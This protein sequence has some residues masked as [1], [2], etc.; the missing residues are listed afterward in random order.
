MSGAMKQDDL[1]EGTRGPDD[2]FFCQK[3][4]VWYRVRDCVYRGTH[5]TF[6]GCIDCLQG[7]VNIRS[8]ARGLRAPVSLSAGASSEGEARPPARVVPMRRG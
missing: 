5:R 2:D 1:P 4:R 3:Y 7:Y 6:A 8:T